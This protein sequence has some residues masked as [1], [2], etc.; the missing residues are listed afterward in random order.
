MDRVTFVLR[1]KWYRFESLEP[2]V[3]DLDGVLLGVLL[4]GTVPLVVRMINQLLNVSGGMSKHYV[5]KELSVRIPPK[6]G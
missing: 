3:R 4:A 2:G 5:E 1:H 6:F